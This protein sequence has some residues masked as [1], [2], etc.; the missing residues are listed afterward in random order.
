MVTRTQLR[1]N[2]SWDVEEEGA[3]R[4]SSGLSSSEASG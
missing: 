1:D 2:F 3:P 4:L